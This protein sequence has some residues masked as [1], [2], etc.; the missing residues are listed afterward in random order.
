M[1]TACIVFSIALAIAQGFDASATARGL[2][3]GVAR[4]GNELTAWFIA[5]LGIVRGLIAKELI[6]WMALAL[7][8]FLPLPLGDGGIQVFKTLSLSGCGVM[9][10]KHIRGGIR[11]R[12]LM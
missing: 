1:L 6:E 4:E 7:P 8:A 9:V 2:K 5:R 11:W 12:R 3:A 10:F